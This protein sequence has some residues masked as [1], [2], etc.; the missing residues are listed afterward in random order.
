[1]HL[2]NGRVQH[3]IEFTSDAA[4]WQADLTSCFFIQ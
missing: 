4:T 2:I 3:T 1:M